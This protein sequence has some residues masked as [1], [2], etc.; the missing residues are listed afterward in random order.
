MQGE[1]DPAGLFKKACNLFT[2]LSDRLIVILG[3]DSDPRFLTTVP[4]IYSYL[5]TCW[6]R[7]IPPTYKG[8]ILYGADIAYVFGT[9][10]AHEH[11]ENILTCETYSIS[12]GKRASGQTHPCFRPLKTMEWL[13]SNFTE[14][15]DTILDPF[16][17][18]GTTL[19]AALR[20][21]R[22]AIGVE[23]EEKYCKIAAERC[24]QL[25]LEME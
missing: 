20:T 8:N 1:E 5:L 16:A 11:T 12:K 9:P 19:L 7:R 10:R 4:S 24:R 25:T 23:I 22:K 15:G 2:Q 13:V 3:C 6:L 18:S 21:G 14:E 17:G